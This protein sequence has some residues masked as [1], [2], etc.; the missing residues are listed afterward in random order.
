MAY[1]DATVSLTGQA[2]QTGDALALFLELFGGE[3]L[4]AFDTKQVTKGRH[5]T[6]SIPHGKS[7]RFPATW[8]VGS[9]E[10]TPGEE[11]NFEVMNHA[12]RVITIDNLVI[13]PVFLDILDEA[14][15]HYEVRS[16][17]AHQCGEELA[18]AKDKN[19]FR[20]MDDASQA[21]ET[22]TGLSYDGVVLGEATG[23][24]MSTTPSL[25]I[26]A[27]FQAQQIL[28]EQDVPDM[29]RQMFVRPA[30]W[31]MLIRDKEIL[32]RDWGGAGS[33]S[34]GSMPLI[35]GMELVKTNNIP[36]TNESADT[37]INAK[38]RGDRTDLV[39]LA[40]TPH[41]V[42]TVDLIG[43]KTERAYDIR[44]QGHIILAKYAAGHGILRPECSLSFTDA[45]VSSGEGQVPTPA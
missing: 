9:Y 36:S 30:Q 42:G 33:F 6:R 5:K 23:G 20:V 8:K 26:D 15:Q 11:L 29:G 44:R 35:G 25:L 27:I 16:E 32:N 43:L 2:Q 45:I 40:N 19:V 1:P 17:Y 18:N 3:V 21:A 7:A 13:A 24:L 28:D 4:T 39:A 41:C 22:H 34:Q 37:S 10:H 38:Y 31:Y 14:M 12:E